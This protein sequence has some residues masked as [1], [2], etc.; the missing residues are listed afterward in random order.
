[1][2]SIRAKLTVLAIGAVWIA[3]LCSSFYVQ[4]VVHDYL[5]ADAFQTQK[6]ASQAIGQYVEKFL[7]IHAGIIS[8]S[9]TLPQL[10]DTAEFADAGE[11][12]RGLPETAG[13]KQRDYFK[14]ILTAYPE[15]NNIIIYTPDQARPLISEP[16][17]HQQGTPVQSYRE[18]F[19]TRDWYRGVTA[20]GYRYVYISN[21]YANAQGQLLAAIA[22][23]LY[24]GE[25]RTVGILA[26]NLKLE[27][28]NEYIQSFSYSKNMK[29]YIVDR[30]GDILAHPD[31]TLLRKTQLTRIADRGIVRQA[32]QNNAENEGAGVFEE[33]NQ[34]GTFYASYVKIP[35]AGWIVVT[36]QA[37]TDVMARSRN[38][39]NGILWV[40][41]LLSLAVVLVLLGFIQT[42][43]KPFYEMVGLLQ[44]IGRGDFSLRLSPELLNRKDEIGEIAQAVDSMQIKRQAA[45]MELDAGNEEL[46]TLYNE[47]GAAE[48]K[49][50]IQYDELQREIAER[51]RVDDALSES[52]MRYLS[53]IENSPE[54]LIFFDPDT[55]RIVKANE[56]FTAQFGY[57]LRQNPALT[58]FDMIVEKEETIKA[59]FQLVKKT[60]MLPSQRRLFRHRNG[61]LMHVERSAV[62]IRYQG[63]NLVASYLQD[64]SE[65]VRREQE[66]QHDA[67]MATRVQ[68]EML[69]T[70]Q[71][72]DALELYTIYQPY[73]YVGGDLYF[74]DW[75]FQ[76]QVLRGYLVDAAGHGLAT[77]L[78]TSAMHVLLRE[79]NEMDLPLSDQM[80]WLNCQSAK[81]FNEEAFA[82]AIA[83]E[84]DLQTHELRWVCAGIPGFW[85]STQ[86]KQEIVERQGMY[87]GMREAEN[88][89]MHVMPLSVGDCLYFLTDGLTDRIDHRT[90]LPLGSFTEMKEFIQ[91]LIWSK[92]R[93]DDATAICIRIQAFPDAF[94]QLCGWPRIL[95]F[96]GYGDY[97]RFREQV[98]EILAEETGNP[99]SLQEVAVN[100]ALA[101]ALECRDGV[102]RKHQARLRFNRI[103]SWFVVRVRTSRMGFAGN[104]VLRRLRLRPE[105][106]FLFG[107][108]A[109]MGRGIPIMLSTTQ[110]MAYNSE[111]TEVLLAWKVELP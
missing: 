37:E 70:P 55:A 18:G 60:G 6:I 74:M 53:V 62:L 3:V 100:E 89:E 76:G 8:I 88:F 65:E 16:F 47:L 69:G 92:E 79:V 7:S 107:E 9:A 5:R 91:D 85:L 42:I 14:E 97:R 94:Q 67:Q 27:R 63:R 29:V 56:Q 10:R 111:G 84:V 54:A 28:L 103:G 96:N 68:R 23:R 30:A 77:A 50:R 21:A 33:P 95:Y 59:N 13:K 80:R 51:S 101:N 66:I 41:V 43:T 44:A 52:E 45:E 109:G 46:R 72:S 12:F 17:A 110:R 38:L 49:L 25:L 15:F 86:E 1:M 20:D 90:D 31:P 98:R 34:A 4:T 40:A 99:H 108:D 26:G 102:P 24:D 32:I 82:A 57:D 71:S 48:T 105:E 75:R 106:M 39:R 64:V 93:R 19:A 81:Y 36:E 104:A 58:V 87:L 2:R 83:F 61:V 35:Q 78:H 22:T 73:T 11:D